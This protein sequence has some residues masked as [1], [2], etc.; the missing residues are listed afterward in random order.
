MGVKC[1]QGQV[2]YNIDKTRER[3]VRM[4]PWPMR[5]EKSSGID[6]E[7]IKRR[8]GAE[9]KGKKGKKISETR[10]RESVRGEIAESQLGG[11]G[12]WGL[13]GELRGVG[14]GGWRTGRGEEG[15]RRERSNQ[16]FPESQVPWV[17]ALF[18]EKDPKKDFSLTTLVG[19]PPILCFSFFSSCF[20]LLSVR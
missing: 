13:K 6:S 17:R 20:I 2:K 10:R 4:S 7:G 14:R 12:G 8:R 9:G 3:S 11:G 1:L 5:E 16:H 18:S 15:G 19:T